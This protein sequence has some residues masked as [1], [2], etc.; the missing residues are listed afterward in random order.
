M[1]VADYFANRRAYHAI[2]EAVETGRICAADTSNTSATRAVAW[3][4]VIAVAAGALVGWT[5]PVGIASLNA[6]VAAL[7]VYF[8]GRGVVATMK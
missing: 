8:A 6:I 7:A 3:P 2:V 1:L 4:A 5:I